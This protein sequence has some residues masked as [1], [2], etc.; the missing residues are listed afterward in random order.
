MRHR[1]R[2]LP[3]CRRLSR[4]RHRGTTVGRLVQQSC[5]R[6]TNSEEVFG[7][8]LPAQLDRSNF[9]SQR[10]RNPL[11]TI[12]LRRQRRLQPPQT[13]DVALQPTD[14]R[15]RN[16]TASAGR[17][18]RARLNLVIALAGCLAASG[19]VPTVGV[20][21]VHSA[22]QALWSSLLQQSLLSGAV[23]RRRAPGCL[24]RRNPWR[25]GPS[26]RRG[27]RRRGPSPRLFRLAWSRTRSPIARAAP[28][29]WP[30]IRRP[31][32]RG[33]GAMPAPVRC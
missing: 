1:L 28:R 19:N 4:S 2:L 20:L 21:V 10:D 30:R 31:S 12:R 26:G 11:R 16:R 13:P 3:R 33:R 27:V 29:G 25:K 17:Q 9:N 22:P 6:S 5:R 7:Y 18:L 14:G 24:R 23:S 15:S 32:R 8:R